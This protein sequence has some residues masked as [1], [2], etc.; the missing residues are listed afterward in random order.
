LHVGVHSAVDQGLAAAAAGSVESIPPPA[1]R[2]LQ[3]RAHNPPAHRMHRIR[4]VPSSSLRA[5]PLWVGCAALSLLPCWLFF[6]L[7]L[8]GTA[9]FAAG[10]FIP[11]HQPTPQA[12]RTPSVV[13]SH[14]A[15]CIV[16][17]TV[18][19]LPVASARLVP[20]VLFGVPPPPR[21]LPLAPPLGCVA[22]AEPTWIGTE[23]HS[24]HETEEDGRCAH[25]C[26]W[27]RA[28][29]RRKRKT[30][31]ALLRV[32]FRWIHTPRQS[33]HSPPAMVDAA[34]GH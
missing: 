12:T 22:A 26:R 5:R 18:S 24:H 4:Y 19:G 25:T 2:P 14:S 16:G 34:Y 27:K 11:Q 20:L 7:P 9:V 6:R 17:E 10:G 15:V 1:P 13:S 32:R 33:K 31:S 21:P 8:Q 28:I 29:C 3:V 30:V 23:V